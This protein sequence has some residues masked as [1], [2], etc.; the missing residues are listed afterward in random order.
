MIP[1]KAPYGTGV[2]RAIPT[3]GSLRRVTASTTAFDRLSQARVQIVRAAISLAGAQALMRFTIDDAAKAGRPSDD[4]KALLS[5]VR[6][7]LEIA[8][9]SLDVMLRKLAEIETGS[10]G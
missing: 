1:P 6:A 9:E 4:L 3:C 2:W 8:N 5:D 10:L 7:Q